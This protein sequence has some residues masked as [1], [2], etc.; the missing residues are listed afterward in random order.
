M[1]SIECIDASLVTA[2]D[3]VLQ[4]VGQRKLSVVTAES[5]TAGLIAVAM[6]QANGASDT[7]HGGFVA[8]TKANKSKALGISKALLDRKG[9]VTRE[10][11]ELML[12]GALKR[13]PAD[14][15][16][17]VTGVLGPEPDEDGNP[18]GL[19][20]IG[21]QRRGGQA[22]VVRKRYHS[23]ALWLR[24]VKDALGL[25]QRIVRTE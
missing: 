8:Y 12:A 25:L 16:L 20:F 23:G 14:I 17:A 3:R 2:A 1:K 7:L 21:C 11:A 18:V 15:A 9:S 19:V 13:S 22:V 24:T 4:E 6:S 5:C 10:V